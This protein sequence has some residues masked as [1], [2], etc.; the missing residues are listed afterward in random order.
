METKFEFSKTKTKY[1]FRNIMGQM[2]SSE[3]LNHLFL[4]QNYK[5]N[6]CFLC[7]NVHRWIVGSFMCIKKVNR[8]YFDFTFTVIALKILISLYLHNHN[9]AWSSKIKTC[10]SWE[11]LNRLTLRPTSLLSLT[12]WRETHPFHTRTHAISHNLSLECIHTYMNPSLS[13]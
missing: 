10:I 7:N 12:K 11:R 5:D 9:R 1:A 3:K 4:R 6:P 13:V 2:F 8:V